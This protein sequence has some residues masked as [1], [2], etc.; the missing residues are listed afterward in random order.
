MWHVSMMTRLRRLFHVNSKFCCK[1][2]FLVSGIAHDS[3]RRQ[4]VDCR[5]F[6]ILA[7]WKLWCSE[8]AREEQS[9]ARAGCLSR[10]SKYSA[11]LPEIL[12]RRSFF[13]K[14]YVGNSRVTVHHHVVIC[15]KKNKTFLYNW[16]VVQCE[17]SACFL[18]FSTRGLINQG[19]K[20]VSK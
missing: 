9:R 19:Y 11:H 20:C 1:K 18:V 14:A 6:G 12:W 4:Y 7:E 3:R 5:R 16:F 13:L 2:L 8:W 17:K 10:L 15:L